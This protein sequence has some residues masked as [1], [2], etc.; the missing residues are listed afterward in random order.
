MAEPA[1]T[2]PRAFRWPKIG[3][4]WSDPAVRWSG[5]VTLLF[6]C[7]V[8]V[9]ILFFVAREAWPVLSSVRLAGFLYGDPWQPLAEPPLLGIR[10]AW[11][12]T[13]LVA[14][15]ALL[16]A[17]P[18]GLGIAVFSSEI[19]PPA[20]RAVL[21]PCLELLA[22]IPSVV[23]GFFGSVTLVKAFEWW[24]GMP[25]G[26]CILA[27]GLILSIMVLPFVASTSYEA[28]RAVPRELREA[29]L[30]LGI[31]RAHMIRRIALPRALPGIFA[32]V[33]LGFA[34]AMG[35]TLAVL[36][37]AG[38]AVA[39]PG[40][41]LDRGQPL[42]ALLATELGEAGLGSEKYHALF[43]AG[44][45]LMLVTLLINMGIWSLKTR[46]MRHVRSHAA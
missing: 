22:G 24:W 40:G 1:A 43:A 45:V 7:S 6:S 34:R 17:V 11:L 16:V 42:T 28:L 30:S 20:L 18:F 9:F 41:L 39:L 14:G 10:H 4:A 37:L 21:Q 33:A 5:W 12:S 46:W 25:A 35:E 36:L 31:T 32:G 19:A 15:V 29:A 8:L 3:W 23:Y 38:N 27:A 13:L 26:E 2:D 44:L